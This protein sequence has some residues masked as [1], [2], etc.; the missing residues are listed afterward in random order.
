MRAR[1]GWLR[2]FPE[3]RSPRMVTNETTQLCKCQGWVHNSKSQHQ[4]TKHAWIIHAHEAKARMHAH[5]RSLASPRVWQV[6]QRR[7]LT[8]RGASAVPG[9]PS[10]KASTSND[11]M[12][13]AQ[14]TNSKSSQPVENAKACYCRSL[15]NAKKCPPYVWQRGR[16]DN[17][18]GSV[19]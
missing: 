5:M 2:T 16:N 15:A 9:G 4:K 18:K 6:T 17:L 3:A 8:T 13:P 19:W 11:S 14:C 10:R 12:V 7:I 1:T